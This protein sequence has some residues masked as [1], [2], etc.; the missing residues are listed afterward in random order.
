M[1]VALG[2]FSVKQSFLVV[3]H[4]STPVI[5]G[6]D[7]LTT[8]GFILNFKQGTFHRA[9]N[10]MQKLQLLPAVSTLCHLITMDDD[11]PQAIPTICRDHSS[12]TEDM[13]SDVHPS[14][15]PVLE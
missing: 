3:E 9:E 12:T 4:L 7:Y 13:P 5:L 10:P 2:D 11:C 14:L 6:C 1:T 15:T 8:N